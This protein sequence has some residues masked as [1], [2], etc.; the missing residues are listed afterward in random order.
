L[1]R[2]ESLAQDREFWVDMDFIFLKPLTLS[3]PYVFGHQGSGAVSGAVLRA[4][5]GLSLVMDLQRLSRS[6]NRLPSASL[7]D[8]G[9][10]MWHKMLQ[11]KLSE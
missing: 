11:R 6:N 10:F 5:A 8:Y 2:S 9:K 7:R 3:E 1:W 4:P